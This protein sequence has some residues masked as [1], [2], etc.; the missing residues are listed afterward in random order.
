[1]NSAACCVLHT[2]LCPPEEVHRTLLLEQDR[3]ESER[4][5]HEKRFRDAMSRRD[6]PAAGVALAQMRQAEAQ[7]DLAEDRLARAQLTAPFDAIVVTGDLSQMIGS[8]V[9][10]GKVLF[11]LAPL[12]A[13]RVILKVDERDIRGIVVTQRG[14][15]VL[16]GLTGESLPFTVKNV[17]VPE[18]HDGVNTFRVEALLD[19]ATARLRPG[20][21]GVGKVVAGQRSLFWIWTHSAWAWIIL[22]AWRWWP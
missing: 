9:E 15:L 11:E 18:A 4:T 17:S 19:E 2:L 7:R 22:Q 6:K 12:D 16:A 1:M 20:M 8:P 10:Q 5:Q 13:Y 14:R 3:F 21:Q